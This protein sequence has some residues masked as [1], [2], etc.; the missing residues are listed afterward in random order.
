MLS[1]DCKQLHNLFDLPVSSPF[2]NITFCYSHN[3]LRCHAWNMLLS[4]VFFFYSSI[5]R[6]SGCD[7]DTGGLFEHGNQT[8]D[9]ITCRE[10][11][12]ELIDRYITEF[13]PYTHNLLSSR[14]VLIFSSHLLL[15]LLRGVFFQI[16]RLRFW[17]ISY[18]PYISYI[19]YPKSIGCPFSEIK[20]AG[21]W[22]WPLASI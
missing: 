5:L 11:L 19:S 20:A 10:F 9:S 16:F 4:S 12:K 18:L 13:S 6:P 21:A 22:S 17:W 3:P 15:C 14:A 1:L 7:T 2:R 8:L